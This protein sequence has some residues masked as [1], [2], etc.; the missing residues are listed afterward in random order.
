MILDT[1]TGNRVVT[2]IELLSPSNKLPG[3]DRLAYLRKGQAY[4]EAGV[5][6]VEIDLVR[7]GRFFLTLAEDPIPEPFQST[8]RV[9]IRA[10]QNR[11]WPTCTASL[12]QTDCRSFP[13]PSGTKMPISYLTFNH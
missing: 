9:C 3:P 11:V 5:N 1:S 7:A 4:L 8:Y 10:L 12:Y 6:L 13:S 2:A